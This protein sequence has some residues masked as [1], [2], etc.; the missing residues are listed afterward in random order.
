M[1]C[2]IITIKCQPKSWDFSSCHS[3]LSHREARPATHA[4]L[5]LSVQT[6]YGAS[7][8]LRLLSNLISDKWEPLVDWIQAIMSAVMCLCTKT[9]NAL[10]WGQLRKSNSTHL[11]R[12]A[13]PTAGP[14]AG[15]AADATAALFARTC[16]CIC[17]SAP[18]P[19]FGHVT[20]LILHGVCGWMRSP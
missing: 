2:C 12:F 18:L 4:A 9:D 13:F 14:G 8:T 16:R 15:A 3:A 1:R 10:M 5:D 17:K 7:C 11:I 6:F 20:V 19:Q